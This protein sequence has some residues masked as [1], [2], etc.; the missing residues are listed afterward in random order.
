MIRQASY[1]ICCIQMYLLLFCLFGTNISDVVSCLSRCTV[2]IQYLGD[3]CLLEPT[4]PPGDLQYSY[5]S[6]YSAIQTNLNYWPSTCAV[7]C[8]PPR[9]TSLCQGLK[10]NTCLAAWIEKTRPLPVGLF[11]SSFSLWPICWGQER[12]REDKRNG[13]LDGGFWKER[14]KGQIERTDLWSS[15]KDDLHKNKEGRMSNKPRCRPKT[16]FSVLIKVRNDNRWLKKPDWLILWKSSNI[17]LM[18]LYTVLTFSLHVCFAEEVILADD[19]NEND[20]DGMNLLLLLIDLA[21]PSTSRLLCNGIDTCF[22]LLQGLVG[23]PQR[24]IRAKLSF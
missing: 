19:E 5:S 16:L 10:T 12:C 9:L 11:H 13:G 2:Y 14:I 17:N 8:E 18:W 24:T 21:H 7:K 6:P 1:C 15:W 22:F 3:T 20:Y 23:E 4:I